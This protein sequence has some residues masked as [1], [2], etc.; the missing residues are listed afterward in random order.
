MPRRAAA[1]SV[2]LFLTFAAGGC[3]GDLFDKGG[4]QQWFSQPLNVFHS[5]D[6][7]KNSDVKASDMDTGG[8]VAPDELVGADG[9]CAPKMADAQAAQPATPPAPQPAAN[10]AIGSMTGELGGEPAPLTATPAADEPTALGGIALGMTECQAARRAGAPANVNISAGNQGQRQVVLTYLSGPWPG[11]YHF[12]DGRLKEIEAAPLPP[13]PAKP[14]PKKKTTVK[15]KKPAPVPARTS[16]R[17]Y[18]TVR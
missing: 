1:L 18:E 2:I 7:A 6:W 10:T 16:Q 12:S 15:K 11:I 3:S 17:D 4:G 13:A 14:G 5:P 9:R 8:P